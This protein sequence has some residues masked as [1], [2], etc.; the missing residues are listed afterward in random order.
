MRNTKD[1][2]RWYGR[3]YLANKDGVTITALAITVI[4]LIILAGVAL[5]MNQGENG[6]L[7]RANEAK[8]AHKYASA[9]EKVNTQIEYFSDKNNQNIGK[10]NL[11]QTLLNIQKLNLDEVD[12]ANTKIDNNLLI[13]KLKNGE[14]LRIVGIGKKQLTD[15]EFL[16][17][18]LV[19]E[20]AKEEYVGQESLK[21]N[22]AVV[23]SEGCLYI[24]EDEILNKI[25]YNGNEYTII[26]GENEASGE[27]EI[28]TVN[29]NAQETFKYGDLYQNTL[30]PN[31][32][33]SVNT[34]GD[35]NMSYGEESQN[36]SNYV[37][38]YQNSIYIK[39][40]EDSN[41]YWFKI[42]DVLENGKTLYISID[43]ENMTF[44]HS[45]TEPFEMPDYLLYKIGPGDGETII[46]GGATP[47]WCIYI[48][49]NKRGYLALYYEEGI[50]VPVPLLLVN[51]ND[52]GTVIASVPEGLSYSGD[53]VIGI[54][55]KNY[56]LKV[57]KSDIKED[58]T[59]GIKP[60]STISNSTLPKINPQI[61]TAMDIYETNKQVSFS[62]PYN[63]EAS[64]ILTYLIN[65]GDCGLAVKYQDTYIILNSDIKYSIDE[66]NKKLTVDEIDST[67]NKTGN[68]LE[69][70]IGTDIFKK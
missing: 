16:R 46:E 10:I 18:N 68:T 21:I 32:F 12:Y 3:G 38:I 36:I 53:P 35:V 41:M 33:I 13:V 62:G 39:E 19:G 51:V 7:T 47:T 14:E 1:R 48:N 6:I 31:L 20:I 11:E 15:L 4:V 24:V 2:K 65:D 69:Y 58:D 29:L 30:N 40:D 64:G 26:I 37:R 27:A 60:G 43:D 28:T 42:G 17:E 23:K 44:V 56:E 54:I 67:L 50:I 66:E 63:L 59:T 25:T 34:N 8:D 5:Y 49:K 45:D 9:K 70:T 22:E 55:E 61:G 52:L 57:T